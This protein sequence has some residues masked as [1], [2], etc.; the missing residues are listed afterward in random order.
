MATK[1]KVGTV[2]IGGG[3]Q[4]VPASEIV[5]KLGLRVLAGS[6]NLDAGILQIVPAM[7]SVAQLEAALNSVGKG[8]LCV[9]GDREEIMRLALEKGAHL[10]L[11]AGTELPAELLELAEQKGLCVFASSLAGYAIYNAL[12]ASVKPDEPTD[13]RNAVRN[14]MSPPQYLYYNDYISDWYR[15]YQ[16]ELADVF[17]QPVVDDDQNVCGSL[18]IDKAFSA[19]ISMKISQVYEQGPFACLVDE[20]DAMPKVMEQMLS[21]NSSYAYVTRDGRLSGTISPMDLMRFCMYSRNTG[22]NFT[23]Y[24]NSIEQLDRSEDGRHMVFLLH[25]PEKLVESDTSSSLS[26]PCMLSAAKLHFQQ[27]TGMSGNFENGSF[28][29]STGERRMGGDV[30]LDSEIKKQRDNSCIIAVELY[31][32]VARYAS[33]TFMVYTSADTQT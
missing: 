2:R 31:D 32:D 7:G 16:A 24:A 15:M 5:A 12:T 1:K 13:D 14:W 29:S 19:Q 8:A 11:T 27:F 20:E 21:S 17:R 33:A 3:R 25:L 4:D 26:L 28:Y 10:L 30:M 22:V 18:T 9:C 6:R 23:K